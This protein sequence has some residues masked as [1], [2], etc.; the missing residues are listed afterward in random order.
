MYVQTPCHGDERYIASKT[1]NPN[2]V[3]LLLKSNPGSA[4]H[5]T[6]V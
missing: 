2:D 1:V 6:N 4:T 3:P 5:Y